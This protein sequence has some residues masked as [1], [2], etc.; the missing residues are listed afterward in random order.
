[1]TP[2]QS[3][4]ASSASSRSSSPRSTFSAASWSPSACSGCTRR[5]RNDRTNHGLRKQHTMSA[6]LAALLYLV[7]RLLLEK[8]KRGLSSPETSRQGNLFGIIGMAIA[9]LTKLASHPT[10]GFGA[11]AVV[12]IGL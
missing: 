3:G 4:H 1:M 11:W 8:K 12:V 5:R 2:G 6:D 10:A 7:C 9:I